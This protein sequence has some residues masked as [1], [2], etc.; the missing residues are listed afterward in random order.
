[1]HLF[2]DTQA[3]GADG[4][5]AQGQIRGDFL[6]RHAAD[7][8]EQDLELAVRK[9]L[10]RHPIRT[11][12]L[13][14]EELGEGCAEVTP[15]GEHLFH[16]MGE[17]FEESVL[18]HVAGGTGLER[19][20]GELP[21]R[22]HAEDKNRHLRLG[23]LQ[24]ADD[25]DPAAAGHGDIKDNDVPRLRPNKLQCLRGGGRLAE[26]SIRPGFRQ[27]LAYAAADNGVVVGEED[28]QWCHFKFSISDFCAGG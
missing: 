20:H 13:G 7:E 1:M 27:E 23:I 25:I 14:G 4:V 19:P 18:G 6:E 5:Y 9:P 21:F 3:V 8:Q 17:F 28:F 16:R 22:V 11:G 2:K 24:L 12:E 10:M 15:A 26:D